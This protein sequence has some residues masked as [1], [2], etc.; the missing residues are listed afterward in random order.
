M[1]TPPQNVVALG[2]Q[3]WRLARLAGLAPDS[4]GALALAPVP[5][6][7]RGAAPVHLLGPYNPALVG[8]TVSACGEVVLALPAG[9]RIAVIDHRCADQGLARDGGVCLDQ[10]VRAG[11]SGLAASGRRVYAADPAAGGVHV[12]TL[13]GLELAATWT[14]AAAAPARLAVDGSGRIYVLDTTK[15]RLAR[16]RADGRPDAQYAASSAAVLAVGLDLCVAADGRAFV[17]AAGQP[18]LPRFEASGAALPDLAAPPEAPGFRPGALACDGQRL[19]VADRASGELWTY[20]L[21]GDRWLGALPGFHAPVTGLAVDGEGHLYVRTGVGLE[22]VRLEAHGAYVPQGMLE[23]GPFDAG[24]GA[25]WMRAHV[26]ADVPLGTR[27]ILETALADAPGVA[28]ALVR[29]PARDV[30]VHAPEAAGVPIDPAARFLWVR[31][32]L[33]TDD[34][35]V[36]PRVSGVI[37]ETPGENYLERLPV[38][39]AGA[40]ADGTGFLRASLEILRAELGDQ[41]AE[42]VNLAARLDPAV[43]PPDHLAWL[44]SWIAVELPPRASVAEARALLLDA[45]RLYERRGTL[46][47]LREMVRLYTG[48]VCEIAETFRSRRL[49]ALGGPACLGF[50]T[51]LLPA[52]PDGMVVPGPAVIDPALQGLSASY[53]LDDHFGKS[54]DEPGRGGD[55]CEP[56]SPAPPIIDRDG[57]FP[58]FAPPTTP[59]GPPNAFSVIWTGQV[60]ARFPEVYTFHFKCDGGARVFVGGELI[61]DSWITPWQHEPRGSVPLKGER[62]HPLRIEHWSTNPASP[63][64]VLSWSSRSQPKEPVPQDCLYAVDDDNVAPDLGG[65]PPLIVGDAIVGEQGPLA[66]EDFGAPLFADAAHHFT[67]RVPARDA[68]RPGVLDAVRAVLDAEKPAHTDY[69]LCVVEPTFVVGWQARVGVDAVIPHPLPAGRYGDAALGRDARLGVAPGHGDSLRIEENLRIG[70][71]AI[72]R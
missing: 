1:P 6:L 48:V 44:A 50:D 28:P 68:R 12:L 67:V 56:L 62:W 54:A 17:S 37:A 5:A 7:P 40:D 24:Y 58:R 45:H 65:A 53:F 20:D 46:A 19:Y 8:F 29:Q 41:E 72:L 55:H 3:G 64:P 32:R 26:V 52:L 21:D 9:R 4:K 42:I 11:V 57:R 47:G 38:I 14:G 10:V 27:V 71:S 61:I 22:N 66:A 31:V 49:W 16:L 36:T 34:P 15:P 60:F 63:A 43:A 51:G 39:Y 69:H 33:E 2:R 25:A 30:M 35:A 59:A 70:A 18:D 13:P 23:A